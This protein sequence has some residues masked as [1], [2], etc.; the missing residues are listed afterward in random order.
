VLELLVANLVR[1]SSQNPSRR[2]GRGHLDGFGHPAL[3]HCSTP[4]L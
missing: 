1:Q 3:E 4:E 2:R